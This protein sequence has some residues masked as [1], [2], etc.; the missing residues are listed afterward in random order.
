MI[1]LGSKCLSIQRLSNVNCKK[2][3]NHELRKS[4][5][6]NNNYRKK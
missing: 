1:S 3:L 5:G 2:D 6:I 4:K